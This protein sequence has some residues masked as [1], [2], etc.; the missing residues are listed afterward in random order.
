[1][2]VVALVGTGAT[3]LVLLQ[4]VGEAGT[5]LNVTVLE[6]WPLPKLVPLIV[7]AVPAAPDVGDKLVMLGAV[8]VKLTPLLARPFVVTTTLPVVALAGTGATML[9]LLQLVADAG[10]PLKVTVLAPWLLPKLVPLI[11]TAVSAGPDVGDKLV[12]LGAVTVKLTPVLVSPFTVTNTLPVVALVG[13]GTTMLV[14]LQLVGA[15]GAPLKVTVLLP[16]LV[17]KFVPLT[18]TAVPTAPDVGDK[19]V[20]LGAGTVKLTPV[21]VSPLAVT[22]TL[23]VVAPLGT[24]TTMLV[25][26]QLVGAAG[27]PLKATVLAPWLLP[28]FVPLTVTA[29]PQIPDA[30]ERLAIVGP[31]VKLTPLLAIPP[32]VATTFPVVAPLGTGTTILVALQLEGVAAVPLNL[33]ALLPCV[34]PKLIPVSVTDVATAPEA[35]T[36]PARLG[37]ALNAAISATQV[38]DGAR[39]HV[40][41]TEPAAAWL[42]SSSA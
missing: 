13:T 32:T 41:A 8:T 42:A 14:L 16:W 5:P 33:T 30:G 18:V 2:P 40:A 38:L 15:A 7:T 34:L 19:L 26:L 1:L 22:T 35:G 4:L 36:M 17:P 11:V 37:P 28:K 31:T 23:P 27:T 9:V 21:L 6:P 29:V 3:M 20:M 10:T 39:V 12:M 25:L 24:G